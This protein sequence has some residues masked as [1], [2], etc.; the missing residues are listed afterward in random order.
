M[1]MNVTAEVSTA[2]RAQLARIIASEKFDASGRNRRFFEYIVEETL[3]G[4]AERIKAYSVATSVFGRG[5]GFDPQFDPVVRIEAHRLRR[6]LEYYYLTAGKDDSVRISVPKGGYVPAFEIQQHARTAVTPQESPRLEAP[7]AVAAELGG[8]GT[9]PRILVAPFACDSKDGTAET[10]IRTLTRH[11]IAG[12]TR[13]QD[14]VVMGPDTSFAFA[15]ASAKKRGEILKTVDMIVTGDLELE[16]ERFRVEAMLI[17]ARIDRAIW[18]ETF[19]RDLRPSSIV[20]VRDEV[21]ICIV[22]TLAQSCGVIFSNKANEVEGAVAE[23][24]GSFGC[25]ALYYRY[26]RSYDLRLHQQARTCLERTVSRDPNYAEAFAC[27]SQLYA[28]TFRFNF[29]DPAEHEELRRRSLQLAQ[30]A[31]VLAPRSSRAFHALAMAYWFHNE[32]RSSLE[33]YETAR[34]LN[35]NETEVMA[36]LGLRYALL[37]AWENSGPLLEEAYRRNPA[38][39][40]SYRIGLWMNHFAH[41]RYAESL[42]E[43]R[44]VDAPNVTYGFLAEAASLACLG[45]KKEAAAAIGRVLEI[46]PGYGSRAIDDLAARNMHP[47]LAERVIQSLRAAGLTI[48][49]TIESRGA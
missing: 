10:V 16:E 42:S 17:D 39:P 43:A 7:A 8:L 34:A 47:E 13:F 36:D 11:L 49:Q 9:V 40:G 46:D 41:G 45:R 5:D 18:A 15:D 32:V 31:V 14:L 33:A 21:A 20:A 26:S 22:T 2:V 4:R 30:R 48:M 35:P 24:L 29:G 37:A 25:V 3:Q 6:S 28:D 44:K 27:L 12:L 23:D 19:E 38:L 1:A